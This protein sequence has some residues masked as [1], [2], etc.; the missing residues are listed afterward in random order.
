MNAPKGLR[1]LTLGGIT[2]FC[3]A[4]TA[5]KASGTSSSG[6]DDVVAQR[7]VVVF[8]TEDLRKLLSAAGPAE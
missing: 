6:A 2:L 8:T 1:L 7:G 4:A 5:P 3:A